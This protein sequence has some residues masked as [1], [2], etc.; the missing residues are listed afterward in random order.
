MPA[1]EKGNPC[2]LLLL[3]QDPKSF[4]ESSY[5]IWF[6]LMSTLI[7]IKKIYAKKALLFTSEKTD[8]VLKIAGKKEKRKYSL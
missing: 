2:F 3:P 5:L 8:E 7:Q 4:S 6:K 1:E